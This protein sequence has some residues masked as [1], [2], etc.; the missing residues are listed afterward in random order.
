MNIEDIKTQVAKLQWY[1][2][3]DLGNGIIT[4]GQTCFS[5][6]WDMIRRVRDNL[7]YKDKTV[8]DIGSYD[9][10][11]AFEAEQ[12]GAQI[13]VATD[14]CYRAY[15][16]FML[17]LKVLDSHVIPYYN[18]SPYNLE[19][20]L[21]TFLTETFADIPPYHR[22]FDIVQYM[23]VLYHLRDPM[24]SLSQIRSCMKTGG[25]LLIETAGISGEDSLLIYNGVPPKKE[26]WGTCGDPK[27]LSG[28]SSARFGRDTSFF[29]CPTLSCLKEML[30]ASLFEP[31]NGSFTTEEAAPSPNT[32][33]TPIRICG[34][35]KAIH[36]SDAN[37][38]Y[39][40]E[41]QRTYRNPG[42]HLHD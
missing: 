1:H 28:E 26:N 4:P 19:E 18:I 9:G 10:M 39:A 37:A 32:N 42:L 16:N 14:C 2:A 34:V 6:I 24:L 8:L 13:V 21:D 5:P 7:D 27:P 12:L 41:L 17:C 33:I 15:V 20:R 29:W 30:Q 11:F 35:A 3:I 22:L 25:H 38:E 36:Y 40:L 23:G 31:I